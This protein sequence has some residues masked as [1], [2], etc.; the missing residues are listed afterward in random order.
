MSNIQK[1]YTKLYRVDITICKNKNEMLDKTYMDE[2]NEKQRG[3]RISRNSHFSQNFL[4]ENVL[5]IYL[6]CS[7]FD[8]DSKFDKRTF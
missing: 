4:T 5:E 6:T 1:S 3:L 2:T 8:E 7:I